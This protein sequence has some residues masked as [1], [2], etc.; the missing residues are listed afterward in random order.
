MSMSGLAITARASLTTLT[1]GPTRLCA[2]A[3]SRSATMVISMPRPARR[4]ISC[5][6]RRST[7]KVPEPTTPMPKRPTCIGFIKF[8][9][10]W[11]SSPREIYLSSYKNSSLLV[12]V[13]LAVGFQ[14]FGHTANGFAQ[15]IFVRQKHNP[16]M[17][18]RGPVEARS[19]HQH[20][21][22]FLQQLQKELLVVGDRVHR[23]I[24]PRKHIQ[25][26]AR[27]DAGHARDR[28]DQLIGQIA[29]AAQTPTLAHQVIDALVAPER[30]LD[31]PLTRHVGTQAHVREH[32]QALDV[33]HGWLLVTRNDHPA[34]PVT[35]RAVA[36]G[37]GVEGQRQHI[38]AQGT[39]R[40][41]AHAVVQHFVVHLVGKDHQTVLTRNLHDGLEQ[42]I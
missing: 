14:K 17:V 22:G 23:W 28:S 9:V 11:A 40:R 4:L 32:V 42:F 3:T 26:G 31:R 24:E 39:N 35:A 27:L 12:A 34:R 16:E 8:I 13:A 15:I 38:V 19:L 1:S 6:L 10:K 5:W 37:Q 33:N 20:D 2:R 36:L 41:V 25:R 7:L 29:L 18:R 21:A 30:G